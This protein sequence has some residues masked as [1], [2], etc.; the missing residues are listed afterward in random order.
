MSKKAK[1]GIA[2]STAALALAAYGGYRY[3]KHRRRAR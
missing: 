1:I 2:L 3:W